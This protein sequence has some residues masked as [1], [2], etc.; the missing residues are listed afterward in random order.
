VKNW[1]GILLVLSV[2]PVVAAEHSLRTAG[3]FIVE[4]LDLE[5]RDTRREREVPA[6]L[7]F[8]KNATNPCPVI[9]FS[10]G[11]GGTR[12][13]YEYLGQH[14]ASHG[15]VVA[16]VQH[17]GSDDAAWRGAARPGEMMRAAM[18]VENSMN[19]PID[20]SFVLD[21][22]TDFNGQD[23]VLRKRMDLKRV[24]VAGHS[25][26]AFTTMAIAGQKFGPTGRSFADPRVKAAIA[27]STPVPR[28]A[29]EQNYADIT[30][31]VFHFTGTADESPLNDTEAT[32]RRVPFD[33]IQNAMQ[34]L[35]TFQDGDHMIFSGRSTAFSAE[36]KAAMLDV[37][38]ESTTQFW[39]AYLRDDAAAKSWLT[40][41]GAKQA[42][43]ELGVFEQ[44]R[45]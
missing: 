34:F 41:G 20:V 29:P 23:G 27:M 17:H 42:L 40:N 45:R 35:I 3:P 11:L 13:N 1:L 15:Y 30:I 6:K 33:S 5:W 37:I 39:D 26:G 4:T 12:N 2:L 44:K 21:Q 8:P 14:W 24:G 7:Y 18:N 25:F 22:L 32:E 16:H 38:R 31:P 43:G 28:R 36:K 19:R 10:H 9:V